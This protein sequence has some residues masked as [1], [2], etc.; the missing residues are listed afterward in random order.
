MSSVND[1]SVIVSDYWDPVI[2]VEVESIF[3]I[4]KELEVLDV[5]GSTNQMITL[6]VTASHGVLDFTSPAGT[7]AVAFE[8]SEPKRLTVKGTITNHNIFITDLTYYTDV[9]P[10]SAVS[11]N[12]DVQD[13]DFT[14]SIN[15]QLNV[16]EIKHK[17]DIIS[18]TS[19]NMEEDKESPIQV[20]V[21]SKDL[22][23]YDA[24]TVKICSIEGQV[25]L[26]KN[27]VIDVIFSSGVQDSAEKNV[28]FRASIEDV[29]TVLQTL[30]YVP[31]KN[32]TT[33][34]TS[35]DIVTVQVTDNKSKPSQVSS[36]TILVNVGSVNSAPTIIIS[37]SLTTSQKIPVKLSTITFTDSTSSSLYTTTLT[38]TFG[39]LKLTETVG[40]YSSSNGWSGSITVK[41][42]IESL[43]DAVKSIMFKPVETFTG[44]E[45][46]KIEI[47]VRIAVRTLN[48]AEKE[49]GNVGKLRRLLHV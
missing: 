15:L 47:E 10:T 37:S 25:K 12:F 36:S 14:N 45:V 16:Q 49:A 21:S 39:Q 6:T 27:G 1:G 30:V 31:L 48:A 43:N 40:V 46:I 35:Q 18:P 23:V 4:G 29:N 32:S 33:S 13:G 17:P 9:K 38:S 44:E 2:D 3:Y 26:E 20:S 42:G 8:T 7:Y 19:I 22:Q 34:V 24:V 11:V 5:D 41:G 28:E